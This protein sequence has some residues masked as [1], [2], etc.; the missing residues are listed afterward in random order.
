[1]CLCPRISAIT[2]I[3][4]AKAPSKRKTKITTFLRSDLSDLNQVKGAL[5][6]AAALYGPG[7]ETR[8]ENSETL[9]LL[10]MEYLSTAM[11]LRSFMNGPQL[12]FQ[13]QNMEL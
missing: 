12:S 9:T 6:L 10:F 11:K 4:K 5:K 8:V 2:L 13:I 7:F 1:M 3:P